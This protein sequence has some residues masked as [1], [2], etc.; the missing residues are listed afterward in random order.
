MSVNM[1]LSIATI[2][3][4]QRE[5][6]SRSQRRRRWLDRHRNQRKPIQSW[7]TFLFA[8]HSS[9]RICPWRQKSR[10]WPGIPEGPAFFRLF[11]PLFWFRVGHRVRDS[12]EL[13]GLVLRE[14]PSS[15]GTTFRVN[16]ASLWALTNAY[17][18]RHVVGLPEL[19]LGLA[20]FSGGK[21]LRR[22]TNMECVVT[23]G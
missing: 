23:T 18:G 15:S 3:V 22:V 20:G 4:D 17:C 13:L 5:P 12:L 16:T 14:L 6:T 8:P 11:T 7:P 19:K 9:N 2:P 1:F 10:S 21:N